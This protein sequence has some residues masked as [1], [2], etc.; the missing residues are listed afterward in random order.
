MAGPALLLEVPC[1]AAGLRATL[2]QRLRQ[3]AL[4]EAVTVLAAGIDGAGR[5][6]VT[7]VAFAAAAARD[8]FLD[9]LGDLAGAGLVA[10]PLALEPVEAPPPGP[11]FP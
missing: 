10:R 8:G 5:T 3:V 11:L 2:A 9:G 7:V 4:R 6:H 1:D